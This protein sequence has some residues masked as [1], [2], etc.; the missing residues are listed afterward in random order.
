VDESREREKGIDR[1]DRL[2]S[3]RCDLSHITITLPLA[4]SLCIPYYPISES[5]DSS[6]KLSKTLIVQ[7]IA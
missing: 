1:D 2:K 6:E 4:G 3:R 7:I 5:N